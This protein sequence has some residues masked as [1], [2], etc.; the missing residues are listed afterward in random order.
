MV[1]PEETSTTELGTASDGDLWEFGQGAEY[2]DD[3]DYEENDYEEDDDEYYADEDYDEYDEVDEEYEEYDEDE[4]ADY[5]TDKPDVFGDT[6]ILDDAANDGGFNFASDA[7]D[8][9][10]DALGSIELN[11]RGNTIYFFGK[12]IFG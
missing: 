4:Y 7:Q 10:P 6:Y 1:P 11:V 9:N 8:V 5:T 12:S 3:D 2:E